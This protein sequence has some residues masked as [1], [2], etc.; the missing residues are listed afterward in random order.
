MSRR[1]KR[2]SPSQTPGSTPDLKHD[3]EFNLIIRA[4]G[5]DP[6]QLRAWRTLWAKLLQPLGTA[7]GTSPVNSL[8]LNEN[9]AAQPSRTA[10]SDDR[11]Q[12]SMEAG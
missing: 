4:N 6:A 12:P 2:T 1:A 10:R 8:G 9:D 3:G 5:S 11:K 7:Q